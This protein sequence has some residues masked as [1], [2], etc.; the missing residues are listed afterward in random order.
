[1]SL[2]IAAALLAVSANP[3]P[4]QIATRSVASLPPQY[5]QNT[6]TFQRPTLPQFKPTP[7][8][9]FLPPS[10]VERLENLLTRNGREPPGLCRLF[11][12]S[13]CSGNDSP[14]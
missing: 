10:V 12:F 2:P 6:L 13:Y 4:A 14:G 3:A 5:G 1:M 7:I 9:S 8:F 11:A